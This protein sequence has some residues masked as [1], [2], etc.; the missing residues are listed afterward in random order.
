[1]DLG[2][3][4]AAAP[5]LP[6]AARGLVKR[7]R[8]VPAVDGVDL[9]MRAGDVYGFL[10]PNGAGKTTMLRMRLGL[11]RPDAGSIRLFG[12]DAAWDVIAALA[13][14]AIVGVLAGVVAWNV[15]PLV[16]LAGQPLSGVHAL[17]LTIVAMAIYALPL[18]AAQPLGLGR[19]R[20]SAAGRCLGRVHAA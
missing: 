20:A 17:G 7:Y 8:D 15:H 13:V 19:V 3:R 5:E 12:R 2:T 9:T 18:V 14:H 1:M 4:P 16:N 11:V 6:V 10:G